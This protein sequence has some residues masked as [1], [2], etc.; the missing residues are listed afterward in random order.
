MIS[1]AIQSEPRG[2]SDKAR[3]FYGHRVRIKGPL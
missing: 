3:V 1:R 2:Y